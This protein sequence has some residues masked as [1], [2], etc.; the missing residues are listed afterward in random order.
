VGG[1]VS[2][3]AALKAVFGVPESRLPDWVAAQLPPTSPPAPWDTRADVVF[4]LHPAAPGAARHLPPELR[5]R[6]TIPLTI[7]AF[8]RYRD[9]PVGPYGEILAAPVLLRETP[10]PPACVPFIAVDSIPSIRGGRENWALPKTR[11][12]FAFGRGTVSAEG[13]GW[14]VDATIRARPRGLP[15]RLPL[16]DRQ[17][18]AGLI[19]ILATGRAQ[20]ATVALNATGPE[21]PHWLLPGPHLAFAIRDARMV[22]GVPR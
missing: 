10:M 15:I 5:D 9:T 12:R 6:P 17:P 21:L 1:G 20:P 4:W 19:D 7:G 11:A 3:L 18:G 8:V 16:R 2:D 22:F 14:R 13:E